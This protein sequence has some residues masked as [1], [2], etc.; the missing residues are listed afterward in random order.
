MEDRTVVKAVF[1]LLA[2]VRMGPVALALGEVDEV[3]D[4]FGSFFLKQAADDGAFTG[5]QSGVSSGLASHEG[6]FEMMST[7]N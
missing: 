5:L 3:G 7:A 6:P 4:G 2:G 1:A